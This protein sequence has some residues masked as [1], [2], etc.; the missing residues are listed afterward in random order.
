MKFSEIE[1][2]APLRKALAE[3]GFEDLTPIQEATFPIVLKGTDL[4]ALAETGSGKTSACG[5]PLVQSIEK[6]SGFLQALVIVPTRELALQY[7][8]EIDRIAKYSDVKPF[9]VFGGFSMDIQKA[10][11]KDGVHILIA[12]PGRLI[13]LVYSNL[14]SLSNVKTLVL[15][16]ADEM[17]NMGFVDDIRFIMS[18][19]V[20]DHQTLFFSATMPKDVEQ[21]ARQLL[22]HPQ[23]VELISK[24]SRPQSLQHRFCYLAHHQKV[25][26]LIQLSED[27]DRGQIIIF[28]NSRHGG[29]K[30]FKQI[31]TKLS[32]CDYIHGGLDQN[33][34]TTI[35]GKFKDGKIDVLLATDIA[36]RGLDFAQVTHVVNYDLPRNR[37][38]YTHR[39]GR[40]GRMG[41][42][43]VALTL[44]G[45]RDLADC[46]RLLMS[47]KLEPDWDGDAP[48]LDS[49]SLKEVD[50]RIN[51]RKTKPKFVHDGHSRSNPKNSKR[52]PSRRPP[53]KRKGRKPSE[54][55]I[56]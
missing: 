31:K 7:V 56:S 26:K 52:P 12:T 20:H 11:L 48:V 43:G 50:K 8:D 24:Q 36:G 3:M 37:E 23:K 15:D 5:I 25:S 10:K 19:V 29:E 35:F 42:K 4:L 44:V 40:A 2:K 51:P 28:V 9:A 39:T 41:R 16:E 46:K 13:D 38:S 17:L 53:S 55:D 33:L 32:R 21:L 30:L 18:C 22:D 6:E 14:V 1:L 47:L 45:A 34:R 27:K 49:R 54:G